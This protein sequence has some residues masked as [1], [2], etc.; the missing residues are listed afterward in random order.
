[1]DW[2]DLRFLLAIGRRGSLS[3]AGE[4]LGVSHTTVGRR[5]GRL[6]S[7]LGVRL[8]DRTPDGFQPTDA[9]ADLLQVAADVEEGIHR[10]EGRVRGRDTTLRGELRISTL[11]LLFDAFAP[12]F[13]S[14][15]ERCPGIALTVT[16]TEAQVSLFRR[17]ADVAFR[18]T[19]TPPETLI[20]RRVGH[21]DFAVYGHRDLVGDTDDWNALPWLHWDEHLHDYVRWLDGWLAR[22]APDAPIAMRLGENTLLRRAA[23]HQGIGVH[24]L[25][26]RY[27]DAQADLV[28]VGPVLTDFRRTLWLLTLPALASTP[29]VRAFIEHVSEAL[30][31]PPAEAP[32][33]EEA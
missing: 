12:V 14:F 15:R 6:E 3:G 13:G 26:C 18:M 20:G 23:I 2:D 5:L 8:F 25:P 30:A 33:P 7:A 19:N 24:P 16:A 11:D 31:A 1:M 27:G 21:V 29:R 9:G 28:R 32:P 17:Q 4:A 22:V 10:A